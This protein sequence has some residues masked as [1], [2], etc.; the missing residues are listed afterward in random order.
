MT[1]DNMPSSCTAD[2]WAGYPRQDLAMIGSRDQTGDEGSVESS[3]RRV[4][5]GQ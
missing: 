5:A 4:R 2:C 3:A 1:K